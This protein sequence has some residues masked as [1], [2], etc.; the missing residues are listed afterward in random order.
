MSYL[1]NIPSIRRF[2]SS[3]QISGNTVAIAGNLY[4]CTATLT[5]TLPSSPMIGDIVGITNLSTSTN[6]VVNRA[7]SN[8]MK[9]AENMTF[10]A[11]NATAV[12][13]YTDSTNGWIII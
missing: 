3:I 12:L 4:I 2:N 10:D 1:G 13:M 6:I 5:L 11:I 9:L 7:S 8:I